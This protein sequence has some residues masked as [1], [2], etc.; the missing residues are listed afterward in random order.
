M[1]NSASHSSNVPSP[2]QWWTSGLSLPESSLQEEN[3]SESRQIQTANS[4]AQQTFPVSSVN[5]NSPIADNIPESQEKETI[6]MRFHFAFLPPVSEVKSLSRVRL[7]DPMD[8][9]PPGSFIHGILQA[10]ILEWVA[11]SFSRGSSQ[12][13]VNLTSNQSFHKSV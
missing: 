5:D 7:C 9:S 11:I 4:K 12:P 10:R 6:N 3:S 13:P 1:S 8:C 2:G